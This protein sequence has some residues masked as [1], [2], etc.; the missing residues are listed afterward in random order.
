[1]VLDVSAYGLLIQPD[2]RDE[3]SDTPYAAVEV[4]FLD[5]FESFLEPDARIDLESLHDGSN[6][7]A[8]RYLDLQV[9]MVDVRLQHVYVEGRIFPD[10]FPAGF[11][12][13]F[14][15]CLWLE[16]MDPVSR[17]PHQ[18]VLKLVDAVV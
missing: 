5:E 1:L 8:R 7:E 13:F 10:C 2:R 11:D 4:C 6:G 16:K 12:E 18:V 17:S 14:L 3:I 15:D 9:D